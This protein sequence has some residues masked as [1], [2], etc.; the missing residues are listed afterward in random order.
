MLRQRDDMRVSEI[1]ES[2][3]GEGPLMGKPMLFV[4]LSGCNL[5]CPWCDTKYAQDTYEEMDIGD[6]VSSIEDSDLDYVCWTG[7][8]PL[9][10]MDDMIEA[11]KRVP[12]KGH[13]LET[14]GT[15]RIP[16]G[17]FTSVVVSPKT[18]EKKPPDNADAYKFVVD[19]N[20]TEELTRIAE[21][22]SR[23]SIERKKIYIQ[24]MCTEVEEALKANAMIWGECVRYGFSL[25]PRLHILFFGHKRC[26]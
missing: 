25:S 15:L 24:P 20:D 4:R 8:E 1:F 12:Q 6:V 18:L 14:N 21:Y 19:A 16:K 9:L 2:L 22:A 13:C 7:G 5:S 3:Q 10:Q 23:H 11:I 26:V 17:L